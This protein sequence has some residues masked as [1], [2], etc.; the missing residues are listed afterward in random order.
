MPSEA[1]I[2]DYL[3]GGKDN[4]ATDR[5]VGDAL[6]AVA[7]ELQSITRDGRRFLGRAV[8]YMA[9]QGVRQF[10]DLGCGLPTGGSV[11]QILEEAAP[12]SK[13]LYVDNDPVV[14]RHGQAIL[15]KGEG[16]GVLLADVRNPDALLDRPEVAELIDLDRPTGVIMQG[17]LA[18]ILDDEAATGI[19][20]RVAGR[21]APG[22]HLLLSHPIGDLC[23]EKAERLGD[24]YRDTRL[25]TG[26]RE[27]ARE[28]V[29]VARFLDGLEIVPPGLVPLPAWRP[30]PGEPL[31]NLD[32]YWAVGAVAR[33]A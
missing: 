12:G 11:H 27:R 15:E 32:G 4:F 25:V 21:I 30:D 6:L 26:E 33:K 1:R 8:R 3:R 9:A 17:L 19:V 22:S 10:I 5:E 7:P 2:I 31:V 24:V 20:E 14:V 13:V 23:R 16:A 28:R 29:D 18:V